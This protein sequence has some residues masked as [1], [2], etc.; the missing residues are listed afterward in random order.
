MPEPPPPEPIKYQEPAV[1]LACIV[2]PAVDAMACS[3]AEIAKD[4]ARVMEEVAKAVER[5]TLQTAVTTP[6]P[7]PEAPAKAWKLKIN[8]DLRGFMDTVDI[9]RVG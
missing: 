1:D 5:I 7:A 8:R 2:Q 9:T 4:S 3:V 6:E